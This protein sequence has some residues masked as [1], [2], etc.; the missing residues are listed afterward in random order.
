MATNDII[1]LPRQ[2]SDSVINGVDKAGRISD[3]LAKLEI[4]SKIKEGAEN[5]LQ[6][7]DTRKL[8][9]GKEEYKQQIE[10]QL[11]AANAKIQL[12]RSQLSELGHSSMLRHSLF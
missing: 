3:I 12:L 4:E 9:Q 10:S 7:F 1:R 11:D 8:K 2:T 5:L 6:V